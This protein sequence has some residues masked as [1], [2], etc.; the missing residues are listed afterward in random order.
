MTNSRFVASPGLWPEL[1]KLAT[2]SRERRWVASA[3]FG[4]GSADRLPLQAGDRV[5]TACSQAT[6]KAHLVS[7]HELIAL[8]GR[9]VSLYA[10]PDLH[11]KVYLFDNL[12]VVG[13]PNSSDP[14]EYVLD[15]TAVITS[16]PSV[17]LSVERWF[18]D[19][20]T[21]PIGMEALQKSAEVYDNAPRSAWS[22]NALGDTTESVPRQ[23]S[24]RK[25]PSLRKTDQAAVEAEARDRG[26]QPWLWFCRIDWDFS[27][28][29]LEE[30]AERQLGD[31]K[32]NKE[33]PLVR[34]TELRSLTW[35][36]LNK[37]LANLRPGDWLV[38]AW[39]EGP[40]QRRRVRVGL[41]GRLVVAPKIVQQTRHPGA[42]MVLEAPSDLLKADPSITWDD[43]Q[44]LARENGVVLR[45]AERNSRAISQDPR[46]G[47]RFIK[48]FY[49]KLR[50]KS[51]RQ[52]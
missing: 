49:Q 17:I 6:A 4:R 23:R 28:P 16:E 12:A 52:G 48:N 33:L 32:K 22:P 27:S 45:P 14:S 50:Q 31:A 51:R 19:R 13:S 18:A 44:A 38:Y 26:L 30:V 39:L 8:A 43:F 34:G 9:G 40:R 21:D 10:R 15:E 35:S 29:T 5:L 24:S 42:T 41:G 47:A 37:M 11:G 3:Y 7:P 25:G 20:C 36:Y 2:R 46:I 1:K